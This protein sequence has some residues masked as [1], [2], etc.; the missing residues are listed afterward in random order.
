MSLPAVHLPQRI[1]RR[2]ETLDEVRRNFLGTEDEWARV[3]RLLRAVLNACGSEARYVFDD[4]AIAQNAA[5]AVSRLMREQGLNAQHPDTEG[6]VVDLVVYGSIAR[7]YLEPA[8][9][10]EVATLAGLGEPVSYDVMAAC[11]G[12]VMAVQDAIGRFAIDDNV[13][14]AVISTAA[15]STGRLNLS[16]QTPEDVAIYAA[17]LTVGNA[18][19]ATLLSRE[20]RV[21]NGV[22]AP[23]GRILSTYA[24]TL[25]QHHGLC[26]VPL[27]GPFRSNAA[28]MFRLAR[29]IP[30]ACRET[31]RRAG[32]DVQEVDLWVFHQASDRSLSQI[33]AQLSVPPSRVPAIHAVYGNCESS[34]AALTLRHLHDTGVLQPGMKIMVGS[35]AAG[36]MLAALGVEWAG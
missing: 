6:A 29:Y 3:H 19:T 28:E 13:Q 12:M 33:A 35:A 32:W 10:S 31:V 26:S 15:M 14:T 24:R 1:M 5:T 11:A 27:E 34:S 22:L 30:E 23:S 8:T 2:E 18:C 20:R 16:I 17:G 4:Y 9:A 36:F 25:P 21:V 7:S